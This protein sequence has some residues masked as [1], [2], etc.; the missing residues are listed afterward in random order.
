MSKRQIKEVKILITGR[1]QEKLQSIEAT[2]LEAGLTPEL[3]QG[4]VET[5]EKGC[6]KKI[7]FHLYR[8]VV[9]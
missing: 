7:C 4:R 9:L 6:F 1:D 8:P 5:V 2:M 3:V